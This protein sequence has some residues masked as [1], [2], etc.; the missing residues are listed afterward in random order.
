MKASDVYETAVLT[1]L[2]KQS[3]NDLDRHVCA[4]AQVTKQKKNF[5]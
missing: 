4:S 5:N 2:S 1:L 3:I